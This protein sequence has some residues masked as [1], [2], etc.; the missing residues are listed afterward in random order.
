MTTIIKSRIPRSGKVKVSR[1]LAN[2][3]PETVKS[4]TRYWNAITPQ[5]DEE[6]FWFW[7]FAHLTVQQ[8]WAASVKAFQSVKLLGNHYTEEKVFKALKAS[9]TGLYVKKTPELVTFRNLYKAAPSIFM[10]S[11]EHSLASHRDMMVKILN[12]S[13]IGQAKVSLALSMLY[14]NQTEII[15]IDRHIQRWYGASGD[16]GGPL[17]YEIEEHFVNACIKLGIP[18]GMVREIYWDSIQGFGNTR[19]WSHVLEPFHVFSVLGPPP[20]ESDSRKQARNSLKQVARASLTTAN[21]KAQD[22][23]TIERDRKQFAEF[24]NFHQGLPRE[25]GS[26]V[27]V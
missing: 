4:Y 2:L 13:G 22:R 16:L 12:G 7:I 5:T 19:Y 25:C 21:S 20:E 1:W 24:D 11:D 14:P 18:P 15:C 23:A 3:E 8:G 9:R 27:G 26:T 10:K 6:R 17:Y